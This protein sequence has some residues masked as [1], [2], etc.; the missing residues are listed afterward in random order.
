MV[1]L[2]ILFVLLLMVSPVLWL[3]PSPRQR[4]IAPLRSAAI[5]AGVQVKLES[6]PLHGISTAMPGYRW[7]YPQDA[8]GPR[9]VLVRD[10]EASDALK[11]FIPGWRWRI[12]P[13]RPLPEAARKPLEALLIRLPQDAL[14]IES[15]EHGITLWWWESQGAER[16]LT[17]VDDFRQLRDAL[18]GRA[19]RHEGPRPFGHAEGAAPE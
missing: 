6:P 19:D 10:S 15:R 14:V 4:R 8:P 7:S 18:A 17:Y 16:F 9:F 2:L 11:A 1:W 3:K 5:K 13:L 12:E